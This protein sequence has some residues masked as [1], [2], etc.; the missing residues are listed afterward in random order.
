[1]KAVA[2]SFFLLAVAC[3]GGDKDTDSATDSG[4]T[5]TGGEEETVEALFV[6]LD[7]FSGAP[8]VDFEL[9]LGDQVG[10]TNA[11]GEVTLLAPVNA[12]YTVTGRHPDYIDA[13]AHGYNDDESFVDSLVVIQ[14]ATVASL[15][16][17]LGA[18]FDTSKSI[19]AITPVIMTPSG[20]LDGVVG[21]TVSLSN[22]Y[23]LAVVLDS[24]SPFGVSVGDTVIESA[25]PTIT[26]VNVPAGPIELTANVPGTSSCVWFPGSQPLDA[27]QPETVAG[28]VTSVAIL[29]E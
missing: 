21:T 3:G 19:L 4:G 1:M 20:D 9:T 24:S 8:V 22:A 15:A 18:S 5:A 7:A 13:V 17:A 26:F 6:T 23:D 16:P 2:N 14:S 10:R 28:T 25:T 12:P 29:C 11:S 27:W